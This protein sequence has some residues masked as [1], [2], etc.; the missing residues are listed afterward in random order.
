[1]WNFDGVAC[2]AALELGN[3]VYYFHSNHLL[4]AF[5]G[6]YLWK[7]LLYPLGFQRAL[8]ALQ[9]FTSL[10][11]CGGLV[12]L[13]RLLKELGSSPSE[14]LLLTLC[15]SVCAVFW[16]WSV[17]AQVYALGFLAIAW[18]TFFLLQPGS[19]HK[20]RT[21]GLGHAAAVLG[22]V[23]HL[24]WLVPALYWLWQES[25]STPSSRFR[26]L[27]QYACWLA[28]GIAVPYLLAMGWVIIPRH[29]QMAWIETWLMGSAAV[30]A[31]RA[32]HWHFPGWQ[33]PFLWAYTTL[34]F[35]WGSLW[36]YQS[37]RAGTRDW[38]LTAV[39]GTCLVILLGRSFRDRRQPLWRF[40]ALW[41]IAYGLFL[42]TWEPGTECYR[43]SDAVPVALLLA[44]GL[45][46]LSFKKM[47]WALPACLFVALLP[48]NAA[49]RIYPMSQSAGNATFIEISRLLQWTPENSLYLTTGG[50]PFI[51]LLYFGGRSARDLHR[52]NLRGTESE[53]EIARVQGMAPVLIQSAAT[54]GPLAPPWMTHH[55]LRPVGHGLPW[56][57]IQ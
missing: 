32:F 46:T 30:G 35:F 20:W 33:G 52:W 21:V 24:L 38:F 50:L 11:A 55:A 48:L 54:E 31:D 45:Q 41:L 2:A 9:L 13:Y 40:S 1:M 18:S 7:I 27:K 3:P 56:C 23:I 26:N 22:H 43:M 12:G 49:T 28:I 29:P 5:L 19:P 6:N 15:L 25:R 47:R 34:R 39:S 4:Y 36:P 51:Y 10:L 16:V 44:L 53:A 57:Y 37:M 14:A 42:W 8:P 17:E